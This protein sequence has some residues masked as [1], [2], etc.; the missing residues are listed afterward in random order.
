MSGTPPAVVILDIA[1]TTVFEGPST[2]Y[3]V[4]KLLDK[5]V[6]FQLVVVV[7]I[8]D[9]VGLP[10][11]WPSFTVGLN[12]VQAHPGWPTLYQTTNLFI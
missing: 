6:T 10:K 5:L 2:V 9:P 7:N 11:A 4:C 12:V 3:L 1:L 8:W